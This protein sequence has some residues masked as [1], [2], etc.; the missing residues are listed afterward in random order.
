[1][2]IR[3]DPFWT[4]FEIHEVCLSTIWTYPKKHHLQIFFKFWTLF[5]YC[6]GPVYYRQ[7]ILWVKFFNVPYGVLYLAENL[8]FCITSLNNTGNPRKRKPMHILYLNSYNK[9]IFHI[10]HTNLFSEYAGIITSGL[11]AVVSKTNS[12]IAAVLTLL[13]YSF[14][15]VLFIVLFQLFTWEVW[16]K[17]YKKKSCSQ[18]FTLVFKYIT[19]QK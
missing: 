6:P 17:S 3:L 9:N 13:K 2:L 10:A 15:S 11:F 1:M 8:K 7:T 19:I 12:D 14:H 16:T 4:I 18:H 5:T